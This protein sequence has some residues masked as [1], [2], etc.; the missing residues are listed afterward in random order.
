VCWRT[1]WAVHVKN[2]E[3]PFHRGRT[4]LLNRLWAR[5]TIYVVDQALEQVTGR[6]KL[7]AVTHTYR[8]R[9]TPH[10]CGAHTRAEAFISP[11]TDLL[12]VAAEG[13]EDGAKP[14]ATLPSRES[15]SAP[16]PCRPPRAARNRTTLR[17]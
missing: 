10:T 9:H 16:L 15:P 11:V 13:V 3:S 1:L 12:T 2:P 6:N 4:P 8:L 7:L 14:T 5:R 17:R